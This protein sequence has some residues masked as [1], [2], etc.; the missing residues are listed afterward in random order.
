MK[1]RPCNE[2]SFPTGTVDPRIGISLSPLN[3]NDEVSLSQN[4]WR[5]RYILKCMR[6]LFYCRLRDVDSH[7]VKTISSEIDVLGILILTLSVKP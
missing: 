1:T 2:A 7:I 4:F 5:S 6:M 3:T